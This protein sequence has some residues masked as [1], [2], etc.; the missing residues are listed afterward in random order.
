MGG[1]LLSAV[2]PKNLLLAVGAAAA[3]AQT[4]ASAAGQAV[5]LIV[6]IVLATP[7]WARRSRSTFSWVTARRD[8]ITAQAT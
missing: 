8:A 2:S 3:L 5:A 4:G 1:D 6:F 7:A